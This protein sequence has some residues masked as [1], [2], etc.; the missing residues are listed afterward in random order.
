MFRHMWVETCYFSK[1][2][3][4]AVSTVIIYIVVTRSDN[5]MYALHVVIVM[6]KKNL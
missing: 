6:Q 3:N 5:M 1:H 4:L 2:Q